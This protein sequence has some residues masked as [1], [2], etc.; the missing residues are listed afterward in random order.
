MI[1]VKTQLCCNMKAALNNTNESGC[2]LIKTLF[3]KTNGGLDM[4]YA[5]VHQSLK[6]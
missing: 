1:S 4:A 5:V 2:V 3:T 6:R